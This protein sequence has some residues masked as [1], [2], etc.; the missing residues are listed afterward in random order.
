MRTSS[1]QKSSRFH[2][3]NDCLTAGRI[4]AGTIQSK[5]GGTGHRPVGA[6]APPAVGRSIQT[7]L[8]VRAF[9]VPKLGGRLPPR[10]AGLAV[11]PGSNRIGGSVSCSLS[12]AS[13]FRRVLWRENGET[14]LTTSLGDESVG[15]GQTVET[16]CSAPALSIRLKP[17]A[18]GRT[19]VLAI[20]GDPSMRLRDFHHVV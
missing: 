14:V 11:P 13:G 18:N 19:P 15:R 2:V 8:S 20:N 6:C 17:G 16:A 10:T 1:A 12:F 3:Q 4:S 9:A 5:P 7:H